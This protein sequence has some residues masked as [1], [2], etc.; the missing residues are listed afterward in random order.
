MG[1]ASTVQYPSRASRAG[2][3]ETRSATTPTP[4][5]ARALNA[6]CPEHASCRL[7][8]REPAPGEIL[9]GTNTVYAT[10]PG[11]RET[12][13]MS[14]GGYR[15][16]AMVSPQQRRET[17]V[18]AQADVR[19]RRVLAAPAPVAAHTLGRVDTVLGRR[20]RLLLDQVTSGRPS[21][22]PLGSL[23]TTIG[24]TAPTCQKPLTP[25]VGRGY[26]RR[27]RSTQTRVLRQ[28]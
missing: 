12:V 11:P 7:E 2:A 16:D 18:W 19:R 4:T 13:A 3:C 27:S 23:P 22:P 6:Q 5:A 1:A 10:L 14:A 9:G 15:A 26:P 25:L 28:D 17:H 20:A 8:A 24:L 21:A